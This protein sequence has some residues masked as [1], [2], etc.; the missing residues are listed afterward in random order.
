MLKTLRKIGIMA[1]L[2]CIATLLYQTTTWA[3]TASWPS[4]SLLKVTYGL[5][6]W[7]MTTPMHSLPA[8]YVMKILYVL[9]TTELALALWWLGAASFILAMLWRIFMK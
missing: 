5:F 3:L 6:G 1:W 9:T 4:L 2:G 8:E 7:D